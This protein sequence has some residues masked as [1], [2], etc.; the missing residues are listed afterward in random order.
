[1]ACFSGSKIANMPVGWAG[2]I[3]QQHGGCGSWLAVGSGIECKYV[4]GKATWKI[5]NQVAL[6]F[7]AYFFKAGYMRQ[8]MI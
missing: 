4:A 3:Q 1:M 8:R 6:K 7:S 2:Q 5:P